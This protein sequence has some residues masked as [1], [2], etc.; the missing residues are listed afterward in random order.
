[1]EEY[2]VQLD[3][4]T[5][6]FMVGEIEAWVDSVNLSLMKAMQALTPKSAKFLDFDTRALSHYSVSP[7]EEVRTEMLTAKQMLTS[8]DELKI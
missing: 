4:A 7:D 5:I 3:Y 8:E 2:R 1:M 6:D